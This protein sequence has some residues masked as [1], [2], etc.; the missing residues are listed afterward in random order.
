MRDYPINIGLETLDKYK[1]FVTKA[2]GCG[3]LGE[4]IPTPILATPME[5]C[6]ETFIQIGRFTNLDHAKNFL[7]YLKS[8]FFR[9]LVGIKKTT[10]DA[11]S[12]VYQL[13]PLQDFS[14]PRTDEKLYQKYGLTDEEIQFIETMVA[15]MD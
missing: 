2:Y 11:P 1:I 14:K 10:Q 15:P 5:I 13:V 7:V 9:F 8:K 4:V 12:R 6:T 3:A